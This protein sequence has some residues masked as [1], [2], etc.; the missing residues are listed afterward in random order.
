MADQIVSGDSKAAVACALLIGIA[1]Q[2]GKTDY[3]GKDAV[4]VLK[5]DEAWILQT[6]AKCLKVA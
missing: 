2:E 3:I 6:Y 1:Q 5:A 4:V